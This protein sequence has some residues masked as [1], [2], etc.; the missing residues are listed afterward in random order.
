MRS[1]NESIA[2]NGGA[3]RAFVRRLCRVSVGR[4][5]ALPAALLGFLLLAGVVS[6]MP[7]AAGEATPPPGAFLTTCQ[8]RTYA[9]CAKSECTVLNGVAYCKCSIEHGTS[10]GLTQRYDGKNVCDLMVEGKGSGYI[11]STYS[12][13]PQLLAPNGDLAVYQC[14]R[15]TATGARAQCDGGLCYRSTR[16][17]PFLKFKKL[18]R[19]EIICSCPIY[20]ADPQ[21]P[22]VGYEVL[23]P[24]PCEKSWFKYCDRETANTRDASTLY[25][26]APTVDGFQYI[27]QRFLDRKVTL[28][29]CRPN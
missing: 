12:P 13:P 2:R 22:G 6:A 19:D 24:Y 9:L 10:I 16:G 7:A 20:T 28:R 18:T 11:V 21:T 8:N 27:T 14:S 17:K 26:G 4:R 3:I 15:A 5:A 25:V 29:T 1:D 23:G